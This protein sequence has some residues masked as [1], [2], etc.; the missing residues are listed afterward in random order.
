MYT[1]ANFHCNNPV[2]TPRANPGHI[3][4]SQSWL[5]LTYNQNITFIKT[6][7]H[8]DWN[9]QNLPKSS[10]QFLPLLKSHRVTSL[11]D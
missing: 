5:A 1:K 3:L 9:K 7:E 2:G 6:E 8:T 10:V 11:Y 4:K